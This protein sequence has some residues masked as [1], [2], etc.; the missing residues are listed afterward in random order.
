M[1]EI[2][3]ARSNAPPKPPRRDPSAASSTVSDSQADDPDGAGPASTAAAHDLG[4]RARHLGW[5]SEAATLRRRRRRILVALALLPFL[6]AAL[7]IVG[8]D[9]V[10]N[11][12]A[13]RYVSPGLEPDEPN[14]A[15]LVTPTPTYLVAHVDDAEQLT[16]VAL[17]SLRSNDEGGSVIVLPVATQ[18]RLDEGSVTLQEAYADG[19]VSGLTVAVQRILN[20]AVGE[21]ELRDDAGWGRMVA[22]VAPL[23]LTLPEAVGDR[24]AAGP[25]QLEAADVGEFLRTGVETENELNRLLRHEL[26]WEAWLLAVSR[27][28]EG[29]V[30]GEVEVGLGRFVRGLASGPLAVNSLPVASAEVLDPDVDGDEQVFVPDGALVAALVAEA[31]PYP[32]EPTAGSR[33]R[34]RLL[35]GTDERDLNLRVAEPLVRSGAEIAIS[36]NA[37]SFNEARTRFV[38]TEE[39]NEGLATLL[40]EA[41]GVGTVE[42]EPPED[43]P[44]YIDENERID[45]TVILGADAPGAIGR[46]ETSG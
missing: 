24:W 4:D 21:V 31:V 12:T 20:I 27:G 13:G 9:R 42:L 41:L 33:I 8:M 25:V 35:N 17:L 38:Y 19:G 18:P 16:S 14:Y 26:F 34:V 39:E 45:V 30:P 11:S 44:A 23:S 7:V 1:T 29:A 37:A 2:Q 32:E 5:R 22:P 3:R 36:G 15:A 40:R 6:G 28:D 43:D 46:L 10:W